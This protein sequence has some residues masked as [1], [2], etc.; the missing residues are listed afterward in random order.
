MPVVVC[1]VPIAPS[2]VSN[3]LLIV[4][5]VGEGVPVG[6]IVNSGVNVGVGVLDEAALK[7]APIPR[8]DSALLHVKVAA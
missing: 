1:Q 8:H 5:G 6:V 3:I 7:V 2:K 4:I